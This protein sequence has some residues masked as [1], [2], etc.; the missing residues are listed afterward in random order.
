MT[1][2]ITCVHI[3]SEKV[4]SRIHKLT[5]IKKAPK[6]RDLSDPFCIDTVIVAYGAEVSNMR[7]N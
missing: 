1:I 3:L 5:Q 6:A 4:R 2:F 7:N